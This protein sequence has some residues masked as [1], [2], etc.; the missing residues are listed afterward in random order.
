MSKFDEFNA[1]TLSEWRNHPVSSALLEWIAL[2]GDRANYECAALLRKGKSKQAMSMAGKAQAFENVLS[3]CH[4]QDPPA[5]P[6]A[7]PEIDPAYRFNP[8]MATVYKVEEET[9][10]AGTI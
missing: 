4:R 6:P 5:E 1:A 8:E 7:E 10:D 3:A 9:D 2:E